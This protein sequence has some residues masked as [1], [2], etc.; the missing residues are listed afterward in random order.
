MIAG[1]PGVLSQLFL[2]T[3]NTIIFC[4]AMLALLGG[5]LCIFGGEESE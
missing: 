5:A 2:W 4:L 1:V 3:P